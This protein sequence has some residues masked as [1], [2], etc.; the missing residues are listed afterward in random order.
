MT[1]EADRQRAA[2]HRIAASDPELAGRLILMTLPGAAAHVSGTLS[3][4]LD[5]QELGTHRVSI[6]GG[7][8]RVDGGEGEGDA[9]GE[10]LGLGRASGS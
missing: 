5:V 2:L 6:S 3:F 10:G 4:V 8:A 7:R 1:T 9:D